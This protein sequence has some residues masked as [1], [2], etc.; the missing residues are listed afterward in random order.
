M[1]S[2]RVHDR[3]PDAIDRRASRSANSGTL[4]RPLFTRPFFFR[5][6][7]QAGDHRTWSRREKS[8]QIDG[9]RGRHR[10]HRVDRRLRRRA[11]RRRLRCA[12]PDLRARPGTSHPLRARPTAAMAPS[13]SPD[14][15]ASRRASR[16]VQERREGAPALGDV[17]PRHPVCQDA[18][19]REPVSGARSASKRAPVS[20]AAPPS[21]GRRA[22]T[23]AGPAIATRGDV[24]SLARGAAQTLP[25][26]RRRGEFCHRRRRRGGYSIGV[27]GRCRLMVVPLFLRRRRRLSFLI[28]Y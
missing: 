20:A 22:S 27:V 19:L 23:P 28:A 6:R 14:S 7:P 15:T 5:L 11:A 18:G 1:Q 26:E 10:R 25:R 3:E 12:R 8:V 17:A 2:S 4:S 13:G 24:G 21:R 9:A 16:H